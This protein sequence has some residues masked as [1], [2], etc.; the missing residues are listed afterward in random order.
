MKK[1]I[2]L[3]KK[4][5][6]WD[7]VKSYFRF[8]IFF[9]ALVLL[10][11]T[12]INK[13]GLEIFRLGIQN[14]I[15]KKLSKK[16][17]KEI[18]MHKSLY[19]DSIKGKNKKNVWVCWF[20]GI[21][22]APEIVKACVLTTKNMFKNNEVIILDRNNFMDYVTIPEYILNKWKDG[23]ISNAHF[24]DIL[25][26]ALLFEKGGIWIDATVLCTDNKI[27][28]YV[29][30][31][32]LFFFQNLKPGK[33]GHALFLSSWF[34]SSVSG[35]AIMGLTRDL[36]YKY[37]EKNNYLVDYFLFHQFMCISC[38]AFP[39]EFDNVFKIDN[40]LP[41]I[42]LLESNQEFNKEKFSEIC[43]L[44]TIHKLTYKYD[45]DDKKMYFKL[46]INESRVRE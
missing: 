42:L 29:E 9:Y 43:K 27:P 36:L 24:S 8:G 31:Q 1:L 14:K 33:D 17:K 15:Q 21:D 46:L 28:Q 32:D 37:W 25:R 41:H 12:A 10:V 3:F 26:A 6:G 13:T 16:F 19:T 30:E 2:A 5:K 35:T 39:Q 45:S 4:Q 7:L 23:V 38:L 11:V 44:T 20:Q 34:I 18:E 40:A 22:N